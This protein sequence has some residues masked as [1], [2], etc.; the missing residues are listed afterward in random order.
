MDHSKDELIVKKHPRLYSL[1]SSNMKETCM[2]WGFGIGNGW[3][4][5][6]EEL[7]EALEFAN[8]LI[9]IQEIRNSKL[10]RTINHCLHVSFGLILGLSIGF[11]YQGKIVESFHNVLFFLFLFCVFFLA[12]MITERH[13][14]K[15]APYILADGVKEKFGLLRFYVRSVPIEF[16]PLVYGAIG[17]AANQSAH[18]CEKCGDPGRERDF[19]WIKTLCDKCYEERC[20]THKLFEDIKEKDDSEE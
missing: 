1:R 16:A 20:K 14:I 3:Y 4:N 8:E 12:R 17:R 11:Y 6:L 9:S 13:V 7:S 2:C 18:T 15:N 5:I 19:Y 10:I